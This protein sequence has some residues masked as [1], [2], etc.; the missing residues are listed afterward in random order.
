MY[1]VQEL[2]GDSGL[3]PWMED[4]GQGHPMGVGKASS[5]E[6]AEFD[7]LAEGAVPVGPPRGEAQGLWFHLH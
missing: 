6:K 7:R 4:G 2:S 3:G 5:K 1:C